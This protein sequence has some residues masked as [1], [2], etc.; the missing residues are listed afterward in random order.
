MVQTEIDKMSQTAAKK[1]AFFEASPGPYLLMSM[2]AGAYVAFGISLI[3]FVGAP[4]AAAGS[5]ATKLLMGASFGIALTLVV[6]AGSELFTGNNMFGVVGALSK[7]ISWMQVLK[8]WGWCYLGNW[9]GSLFLAWMLVQSGLFSKAPQSDFILS[10]AAAKMNGDFWQL[11]IRGILANWLVCLAVWMAARVTS[12]AAKLGLIFWCLLG[13]I[14]PGFE[15]S[16][17]NMSMLGISLFLPHGADITWM[18]YLRNLTAS[19]LGNIV[20][21]GVFVGAI[22]WLI[23]PLR[24]AVPET[25]SVP[26]ATAE[27]ALATARQ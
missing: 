24:V 10:V 23:S 19:S 26:L 18:G 3:F 1:V 21:G 2:L 27:P 4:L 17:A 5:P 9:L 16:V 11:F 8:L 25:N 15:H 6:F 7:R 13:F 22:Y 20:G 12:D 14:A